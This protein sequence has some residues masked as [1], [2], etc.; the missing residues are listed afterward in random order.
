MRKP[1]LTILLLL[2]FSFAKSQFPSSNPDSLKILLIKATEDTIKVQLYAYL[3]YTYAFYF[4]VDSGIF[5]S[6]KAIS[7]AK[8]NLGQ[9]SKKR[10]HVTI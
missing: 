7:L 5:Y 9:H 4:H 2:F 8:V 3:G 1:F 6:Q 10:L